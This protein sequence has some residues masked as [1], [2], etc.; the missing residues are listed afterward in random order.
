LRRG[1]RRAIARDR[2]ILNRHEGEFRAML[3]ETRRDWRDG[4]FDRIPS[5][6]R[7]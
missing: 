6:Y 5:G 7:R 3:R 2:A 1:D 4:N